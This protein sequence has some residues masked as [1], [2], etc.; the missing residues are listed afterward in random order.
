MVEGPCAILIE[1]KEQGVASIDSGDDEDVHEECLGSMSK[2]SNWL[3]LQAPPA[4]SVFQVGSILYS[5]KRL[6]ST[7]CSYRL[8]H[9]SFK[10]PLPALQPFHHFAQPIR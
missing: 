5:G 6:A 10:P 8:R 2:D 3:R 1:W 4:F 7:F 9:D